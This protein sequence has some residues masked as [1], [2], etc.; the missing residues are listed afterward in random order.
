LSCSTLKDTRVCPDGDYDGQAARRYLFTLIARSSHHG[1]HG[2]PRAVPCQE[3]GA[4]A[5]GHVAVPELS[6][7]L[8]AGAAATRYVVAPELPCARRR[9]PQDKRACEPVLPFVF[10]LKLV[11]GGIRSLGYRQWPL[12]P[13]RERLRTLGWGQ[14]PSPCSLSQFC[15]L[16]FQSDGATRWICG[17]P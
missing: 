2:G 13:P 4:G 11:S 6:L 8:V 1:A 12:G 14:H 10:D 15:T 17:R 7:V 16:G 9:E 5:T 3:M